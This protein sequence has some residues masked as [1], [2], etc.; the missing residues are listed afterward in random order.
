MQGIYWM[1]TIPV[2]KWNVPQQLPDGIR[3]L[4][5]QQEIGEETGY[6]HW[7]L[8]CIMKTK[9]RLNH[10]KS[11]FCPEANLR[12][13]RSAFANAY[14]WKEETRVEGS[15]FELG[16]PIINHEVRSPF[17]ETQKPIGPPSIK[18]QRKEKLKISQKR[19]PMLSSATGQL[20]R[21]SPS[22]LLHEYPGKK[23]LS[24]YSTARRELERQEELLWKQENWIQSTLR[25]QTQNGGT[26]T[27]ENQSVS[28]T[29]S[30]DLSQSLTFSDGSIDTPVKS[31]SKDLNFLSKSQNFGSPQISV[32]TI[33]TK[34]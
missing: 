32:P 20:L 2:D 34:I 11:K 30:P 26:D 3:Y 15:Q 19:I 31:K 33:G 29:N 16:I 10:V 4:R 22:S 17:T 9:Q 13:T 28:L 7:Q 5:G 12:L 23:L 24:M 8:I 14:V 1:I 27:E 25:I 21:R 6:H 18:K